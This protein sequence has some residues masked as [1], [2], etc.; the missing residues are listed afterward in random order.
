MIRRTITIV[1]VTGLMLF[2]CTEQQHSLDEQRRELAGRRH[3][4]AVEAGWDQQAEVLADGEVTA[5]EYDALVASFIECYEAEGVPMTDPVVHP[6]NPRLRVTA[7]ADLG[8]EGPFDTE[9]LVECQVGYLGVEELLWED[10]D[11][12]EPALADATRQCMSETDH[13]LESDDEDLLDMARSVGAD[14]NAV[15]SLVRCISDGALALHPDLP[16]M[17]LSLPSIL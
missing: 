11:P 8:A 17:S 1:S 9:A 16:G 3:A 13:P 10:P 14:P 2:A 7:P 12:M 6:A 15:D 4:E 5:D